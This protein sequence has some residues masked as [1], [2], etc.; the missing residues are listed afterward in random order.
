MVAKG[1]LQI[2]MA[3]R[4]RTWP[5][6]EQGFKGF[7]AEINLDWIRAQATLKEE[8]RKFLNNVARSLA[9][10]HGGAYSG[11]TKAQALSARTGKSVASILNSVVVSGTTYNTTTGKIGGDYPLAIHEYGG[12]IKSKGKLL[13]IPL[14]PALN[15]NGVPMRRSARGWQNTFVT[16]SRR[17]N[18][19]IFQ[20]RANGIVPLYVLKDRVSIKPRL[21]MRDELKTQTPYFVSKA[22]DAMVRKIMRG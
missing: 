10:K 17:G 6:L 21:G 19:I 13:T 16:R 12:T 8:L 5:T 18:L 11:G 22:V 9:R 2:G 7:A 14:P 15:K 3:F 1:A 4:G 20:R